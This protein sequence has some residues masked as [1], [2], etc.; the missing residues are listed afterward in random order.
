MRSGGRSVGITGT[1]EHTKVFIGGD[2]AIQG[3][4]GSGVAHCLRGKAVDEM[5]SSV[6]GLYPVAGS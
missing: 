6:Q 5:C 4:V 2:C 1:T 3:K